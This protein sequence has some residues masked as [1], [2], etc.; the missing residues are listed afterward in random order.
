VSADRTRIEQVI[1]NLLSNSAKFTAAGGTATLLVE[2]NS[3][4]GQA[5]MK[6]RD[7]GIGIAPETLPRVFEAFVQADTTLDRSRG[8]LGLGLAMVKGLVEMHGGTASVQSAGAGKGA[9]FTVRLPLEAAG[10][11]TEPMVQHRALDGGMRRVLVIEDN[12]DA[13]DSLRE[14]LDLSEH[15]VEVAFSGPEGLE[16]ARYFGPDVVLCDIGLPA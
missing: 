15:T 13:A 9:E 8:G 5:V 11:P 12:V 1:G 14:V 16:K 4:L 10:L 6:V 3:D 2:R 7:T